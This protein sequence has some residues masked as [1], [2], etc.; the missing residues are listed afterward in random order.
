MFQHGKTDDQLSNLLADNS[1]LPLQRR[2][3]VDIST[4][5][6]PKNKILPKTYVQVLSSK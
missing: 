6:I 5:T 1:V 3:V 4:A 2:D